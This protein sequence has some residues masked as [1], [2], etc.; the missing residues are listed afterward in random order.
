MAI[1]LVN[2][3]ENVS[4]QGNSANVN[5][6]MPNMGKVKSVNGKTGDVVLTAEDL[7]A[8]TK[9]YVDDAITNIDIPE[10]GVGLEE[11]KELLC[12]KQ[13]PIYRVD[14]SSSTFLKVYINI[15]DLENNGMYFF[16]TAT[17]MPESNH[18]SWVL[19]YIVACDDGTEVLITN[20]SGS[21]GYQ[22]GEPV[23][24]TTNE[25][26]GNSMYT[27]SVELINDE[28]GRRFTVKGNSTD[29]AASLTKETKYNTRYLYTSNNTA[30]TPTKN[31]H[32]ATKK[33]VDDA[34]A[35]LEARI[36][37]LEGNA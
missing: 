4:L 27:G 20:K 12:Y 26:T 8:A 28:L 23:K 22:L 35:A 30:Y 16:N 33:Y 3:N 25:A 15:R 29:T 32:P 11:V 6:V 10:A 14:D 18:T 9:E 34:L 2:K 19:Y 7:G 31:Y 21:K 24:I 1:E 13:P 17:Q 5:F 36:A 37:A